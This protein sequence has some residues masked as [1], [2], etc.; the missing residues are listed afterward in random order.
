MIPCG[1]IIRKSAEIE[2][3]IAGKILRISFTISKSYFDHLYNTGN[4]SE[5]KKGVHFR[6]QI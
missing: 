2:Q 4:K 5:S 3:A 1:K 6:L